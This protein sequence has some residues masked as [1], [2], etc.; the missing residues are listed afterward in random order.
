MQNIITLE[1]Q[2]TIIIRILLSLL[3]GLLIGIERQ[4]VKTKTNNH[5]AAGLRT[6]ALVCVGTALIT[7]IGVILF[8]ADPIRLAASIMTGIGFIGAGTIIASEKKVMG[9]TNAAAV[10]AVAAI[11]IA[12]GIGLYI[13]AVFTTLITIIVLE[14]RKFER[15]E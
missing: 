6:H 10:W 11:G 3:L 4:K 7:S 13:V 2:F 9:L 12:A 8:P 5:G 15:L 14:L 1:N